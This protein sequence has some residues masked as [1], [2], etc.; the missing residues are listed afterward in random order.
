MKT[1]PTKVKWTNLCRTAFETLKN[2]LCDSPILNSPDFTKLF[3]LQTD[4]SIRPQSRCS[5][6]ASVTTWDRTSRLLISVGRSVLPRE[7]NYST[8]EKECLATK[9]GVQAFKVYLLGNPFEI[10]TD[11]RALKWLN[12]LKEKNARLTKW[13]LSLQQYDLI[14]FHP[15]G[16]ENGNADAL[17]RISNYVLTNKFVAGEEGRNVRD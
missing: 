16:R 8:I 3:V 1:C 12:S 7:Q 17:S 6:I 5:L 4:A 13:S 2:L 11:H 10:Q 15:K 14:V 9:L